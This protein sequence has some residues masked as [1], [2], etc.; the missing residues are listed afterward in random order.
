MLAESIIRIGRPIKN[1]GLSSRERI[2]FLTD[3][4]SENCKNYFRN[5]FLVEI[6]ESRAILQPMELGN[7]VMENNKENFIV[8]HKRAVAFP[9][10]YPNG[11][12]PLHA[13][14]IYALP[15]YLMYD[16][17]IKSIREQEQFKKK[18][19]LPRLN[20]TLQYKDMVKDAINKLAD[21]VADL[22]AQKA[23][24][25]ITEDK[26]LG[27]VM[28]YDE[29][30]PMFQKRK[31][32]INNNNMI[33]ISTSNLVSGFNLYLNGEEVLK[34][35][36][37][38][39]FYEAAELGKEKDVISTFS[40]KKVDEAVSI[41]NKSWLWLSPT[42][43]APRSI[44]WKDDEWT[45]GIKVDAENYEAF[46]YGVQFLKEIQ[47]PVSN[48]VLKEM[49]APITNVEAKKNMSFSS[50]EAIYG[51]PMVLPLVDGDSQ[52]LYQKYRKMLV[53]GNVRESDSDLH[54]RVLAGIDKVVPET[55]DEHRLTI[56]Y[57]SG[58]LSRG[59]MHIRAVIEDVIPSVA[60]KIEKIMNLLKAR[61]TSIIQEAFVVKKQEFYRTQ[62]LPSLLA[63]A[64]GP[65]YVWY[66]LQAALHKESL[67]VDRLRLTTARKLNELANK[68]DWW[69][70]AQELVFYYSFLYFLQQYEEKILERKGGLKTLADWNNFMDLFSKGKLDL[71]HL[72]SVEQ[73]GFVAGLLTKQFSNSYYRKTKKDFVKQR[74]M[75]FGSKLNPEMIW[76][77]GL[78]RSEEL[79]Q[80]WEMKIGANFRP[81]LAQTLLGFL[82]K[83]HQLI[84]EKDSFMTAFWSG[85]LLYQ[86]E[87]KNDKSEEVENN[88]N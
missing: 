13:Q 88:G 36:S 81:V 33:W 41:Y 15:C 53:K 23:S 16:P 25:L 69:Q 51:I 29:R 4:A 61:E 87:K 11:G 45:K 40:N 59:N 58:D 71:N 79:A 38:A 72:E 47:V 86:S 66:S 76:K 64:Y 62:T 22:F 10:F 6:N 46:L 49:F 24:E 70:M 3:I 1:G 12:N 74:V 17:H 8:D 80:Q 77:N 73:L 39:K 44:Y 32:K 63:N 35:I 5:V 65:G 82:E 18:F 78:L 52:Q 48:A 57:Y 30:L 14:G 85:Y 83:Q 42:W 19:L 21:I 7:I 37:E 31:D 55:G 28:I 67:S 56:L 54:L 43:E 26:Q 2:R 50:F 60:R 34:R 68:E 27:I 75:K 20:S 84:P 9:V